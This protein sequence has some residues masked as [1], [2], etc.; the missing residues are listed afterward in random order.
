MVPRVA[1][2]ATATIIWLCLHFFYSTTSSVPWSLS[3]ESLS[4]PQCAQV[5]PMFPRDGSKDLLAMDDFLLSAKFRNESISRLAGSVKIPTMSFDDLGPI[6]EDKRWEVFY[7]FEAYLKGAFPLLHESL[8]LEKVNTHGLLY[9]WKGSDSTLKPT[10]L[11]AHQD[12]VPVPESTIPQWTHPPFSGFYDG[13]YVWGRG[14]SDC[15]N[16]LIGIMEA[17]ELLIEAGFEPMRT[18]ILSFG[19]DEEASG[20]QGA[21]Y[22]APYLFSKYG[23]DA[24]AVAVD[25]G[26]GVGSI[27]GTN[28]AL[29]GVAEKGYIDVDVVLRMPGGHSSIPPPHNGIGVMSELITLIEANTYEPHLYSDNPYLSLLHCGAE[30]SPEFPPK[31]R[32]LLSKRSDGSKSCSEKDHLAL[33]ASKAGR[34][35]KYLMTTSV[36]V[37]VI[38]GGVKVNALPERTSATVNHRIN[39]GE[40]PSDVKEKVTR[41]ASNIAHKYNLT[42][43]AFEGEETP[44]S[45]TLLARNTTLEPAPVTPTDIR[46]DTPYKILS[47]TTRALYGDNVLVAPGI[48]TG[49]TDTRYY[50]D[51]TSH[52]FRYAVGFDPDD[53]AGLGNIHTVNERASVKA[54]IAAVRWF[55]FFI[56]NM[57]EAKLA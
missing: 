1:F 49:N 55:S 20:T 38:Q 16:Q 11:M 25:E 47:G 46:E 53:E 41:L 6:G 35:I 39:V 45:I 51:L 34:P 12:V 23:H 5:L 19:F 27:W 52:I 44:S 13:K 8:T 24:I 18:V 7:D 28:F 57:D 10:L 31:L 43:H 4:K 42:L 30:H 56:R 40:H 29:P 2:A 37:D 17:V 26:A 33:E 9:T 22:L 21:G 32:K 14:A 36:A 3:R 54:H 48:M 50:W 15:K